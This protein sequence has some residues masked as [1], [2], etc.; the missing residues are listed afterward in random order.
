LTVNSLA[1]T[2]V[3]QVNID[4]AA[5]G[6]VGDG[7]SDTVTINGTA[8]PDTINLTA[9]GGAVV[10][11]GLAAQVQILHPEFTND[12]LILNGLG[13][14][15]SFGVGPGVATLIGVMLNQ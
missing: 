13:G 5:T 11:S 14:T 10:V 3:T 1:G 15:D 12:T 6:G 8:L 4:L 9:S 7:A 2:A